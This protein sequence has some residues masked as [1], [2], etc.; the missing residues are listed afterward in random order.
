MDL[1]SQMS[2]QMQVKGSTESPR[3]VRVPW[4]KVGLV[5][6]PAVFVC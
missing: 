2:L 1:C 4:K 6:G 3:E 5:P